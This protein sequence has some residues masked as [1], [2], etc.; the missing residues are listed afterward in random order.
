MPPARNSER[1]HIYE[2]YHGDHPDCGCA[3]AIALLIYMR[4]KNPQ[5]PEP[6]RFRIR[7]AGGRDWRQCP[8]GREILGERQKRV[9]KLFIR[10][11]SQEECNRFAGDWRTVQEGFV[12]EPKMAVWRP[13]RW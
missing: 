13:T 3:F 5:T 6:V 2:H 10:P 11:L 4:C 12:D 7:S 1:S 9:S 8:Q